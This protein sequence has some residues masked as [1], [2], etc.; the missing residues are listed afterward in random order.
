M[1]R[2][3]LFAT[4]VVV[5]RATPYARLQLEKILFG[6]RKIDRHVHY[7]EGLPEGFFFFLLSINFGELEKHHIDDHFHVQRRLFRINVTSFFVMA[8]FLETTYQMLDCKIMSFSA[9]TKSLLK[10]IR[11]L[12]T[13]FFFYFHP[14]TLF[15]LFANS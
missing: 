3:R 9:S 7:T 8:V 4:S 6:F 12:M 15:I 11:A 14:V 10:H 13:Y 5:A 1:S 2:V